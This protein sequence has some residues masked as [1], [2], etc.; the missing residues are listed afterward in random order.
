MGSPR[1]T[2]AGETRLSRQSRR[3]RA[4]EGRSASHYKRYPSLIKQPR[5]CL[6]AQ[7]GGGEGGGRRE[8][9]GKVFLREIF[10]SIRPHPKPHNAFPSVVDLST[11][12]FQDEPFKKPKK[13]RP[14]AF[15]PFLKSRGPA[16][17]WFSSSVYQ[18]YLSCPNDATNSRRKRERAVSQKYEK[19]VVSRTEDSSYS[20]TLSS[21]KVLAFSGFPNT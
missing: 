19:L 7:S 14:E 13:R 21:L 15:L 5:P 10:I 18:D 9:F 16:V 4:A 11:A 20:C 6:S 2:F 8:V 12:V 17:S 3:P 1:Q